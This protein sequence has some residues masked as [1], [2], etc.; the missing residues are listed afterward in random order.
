MKGGGSRG[1][2]IINLFQSGILSFWQLRAVC[3]ISLPQDNP[4]G[5][6][7]STS[8]SIHFC[9]S[10][11]Y[12]CLFFNPPPTKKNHPLYKAVVCNFASFCAK[13]CFLTYPAQ[14]FT[15]NCDYTGSCTIYRHKTYTPLISVRFCL[16]T[17]TVGFWCGVFCFGL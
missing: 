14:L 17:T 11:I 7:T 10:L 12:E 4:F 3:T 1:G 9:F 13:V 2:G 6:S 15:L 5:L 16:W 8:I